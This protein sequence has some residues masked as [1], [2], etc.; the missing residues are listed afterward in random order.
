[1]RQKIDVALQY[2]LSSGNGVGLLGVLT[3]LGIFECLRH[4]CLNLRQATTYPSMPSRKWS[5]KS[6][7]E[8]DR[9]TLNRPM[10]KSMT[11]NMILTS[12]LDKSYIVKSLDG[13]VART[14]IMSCN[15]L[16]SRKANVSFARQKQSG[17]RQGFL[18]MAF[19][20]DSNT[21]SEVLRQTAILSA[22][23]VRYI[24]K[25]LFH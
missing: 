7:L 10:L 24:I 8:Y 3:C 20:C 23:L 22:A 5:S 15:K 16:N 6:S 14:Q 19:Y 11:E 12:Y 21:A 4:I 2:F 25:Q 13:Y 18:R 1:M 9:K 17:T